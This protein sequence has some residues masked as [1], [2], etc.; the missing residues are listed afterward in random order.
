[1]AGDIDVV[2]LDKTRTITIGDR[3]A[4][5]FLPIGKYSEADVGRLAARASAADET[6]EVK[7][8]VKLFERQSKTPAQRAAR[9]KF[10][11]IYSANTYERH[12]FF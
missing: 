12:Y 4:T 9:C 7:S 1:M 11:A 8:I 2:L 6:C 5:N 10:C 3:N